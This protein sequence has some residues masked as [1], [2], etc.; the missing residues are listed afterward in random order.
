M[1]VCVCVHGYVGWGGQLMSQ[2]SSSPDTLWFSASESR[3]EAGGPGEKRVLNAIWGMMQ[4][5]LE[6][7]VA[8]SRT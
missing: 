4:S 8:S 7:I 1:C 2:I 3:P 5:L 6:Y